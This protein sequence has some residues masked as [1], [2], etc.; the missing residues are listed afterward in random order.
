[1]PPTP[2]DQMI[3]T[4]MELFQ[5]EGYRA[6]SWRKLVQAA[7]TPWG[8]AHHYFP[9]GKEQLGVA[10]VELGAR[11]VAR[12]FEHSF[13]TEPSAADA[14]RRIFSVS[15]DLMETSGFRAGCPITTVALETVPDLPGMAAA[16]RDAFG[17]WEAILAAGLERHGVEAA[18]AQALAGLI[19]ALF[20]G[21]LVVSRVSQSTAP[22]R[23]CAD[24][25]A[26][27]VESRA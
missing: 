13:A 25:A 17:Q 26:A 10:A 19:L 3:K 11:N 20:E 12:L 2:R 7:G 5:R 8:S 15:A 18:R 22:M 4:A 16:C 6:T 1:M 21:A 27:L 14:M 23:R 24:Q 9:G